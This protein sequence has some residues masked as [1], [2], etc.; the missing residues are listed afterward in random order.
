[1][2]IAFTQFMRPSGRRFRVE[3]DRPTE[4]EQIA[5]SLALL[6]CTFEAEVLTTGDV[7]FTIT[8][9][10]RVI[11]HRICANGPEVPATVDALIAEADKKILPF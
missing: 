11:A 6:G 10:E 8:Q 7:S 1:M 9:D 5:T 3:I 2:S 4:V